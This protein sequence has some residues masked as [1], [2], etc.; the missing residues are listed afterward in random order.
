MIS[1]YDIEVT[2]LIDLGSTHSFIVSLFACIL[3]LDNK[4]TP[5]NVVVSTPL[6]KQLGSDLSYGDC[7]MKLGSVT[8]VGDLIRLPIEDYDIILGIDW[9][10]RHYAP[11]DYKQKVVYFCKPR[12][13][14]LEFMGEKVKAKSC[15]ISEVRARK[16]LYKSCTGYLAYLLNKPAEPGRIEEVPVVSGYLD[17]FLAELTEVLPDRE[18]EFV[19]DLMPI[20]EPVSRTSYRMALAELVELK[21]QLQEL[22]TQGFIRPSVS[23]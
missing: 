18:V 14:V 23:P 7:E 12:E 13:H 19:L 15:Q 17:V 11:V 8:L 10:S 5:C 22:L 4:G 9:L 21:E 16:L 20:A 6:G 1:L 3:N 2:V